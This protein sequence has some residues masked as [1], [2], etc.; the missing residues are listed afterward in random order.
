MMQSVSRCSTACVKNLS[1]AF[2]HRLYCP[3]MCFWPPQYAKKMCFA[4]CFHCKHSKYSTSSID[5]MRDGIADMQLTELKWPHCHC[6]LLLCLCVS[7][8]FLC[9]I[10]VVACHYVVVCHYCELG[11]FIV[12]H[13]WCMLGTKPVTECQVLQEAHGW[14]CIPRLCQ[15]RCLPTTQ[16]GR[17]QLGASWCQCWS[18]RWRYLTRLVDS[19]HCCACCKWNTTTHTEV[20]IDTFL[21]QENSS[22]A[23]RYLESVAWRHEPS[24]FGGWSLLLEQFW[25]CTCKCL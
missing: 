1:H 16:L 6:M 14:K 7:L 22:T 4:S 19:W 20:S 10:I 25:W 15:A 9:A 21:W 13:V 8:Q 3:Y 5:D 2:R 12:S 17:M 11:I 18:W 24:L 23:F